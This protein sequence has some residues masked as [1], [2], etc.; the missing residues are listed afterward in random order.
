[1]ENA[2][3]LSIDFSPELHTAFD[4]VKEV[5]S[6]A[7]IQDFQLTEPSIEHMIEVIYRSGEVVQ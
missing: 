2:S 5:N 7:Q 6:H 3:T 1:M 4:I